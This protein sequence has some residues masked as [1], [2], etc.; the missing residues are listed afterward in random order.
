MISSPTIPGEPRTVDLA[1]LYPPR[2]HWRHHIQHLL[3][4]NIEAVLQEN[5]PEGDNLTAVDFGCGKMPYR[6]IIERFVTRYIGADLSGDPEPEIPI[7]PEGRV[8]LPNGAANLVLS[9][10]V[11]EH[12]EDP[13]AYLREA[14][15]LLKTD[16]RLV[17]S[18]HGVWWYHPH[19]LDLWRWTGEGLRRTVEQAGFEIVD[20]RG[21]MGL[22]ATGM[23]L[24]QDGAYRR[25]PRW[26][27]PAFFFGMQQLV[28]LFDGLSNDEQ[29]QLNASVFL[30]AA[31]RTG[32]A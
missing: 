6:T 19:P 1:T 15:R 8:E 11:L 29:R 13:R 5:R 14:W 17:L 18:T 21:L 20:F 28:R 24:V 25:V 16:G 9:F 31:R 2:S 10:Q 12:V 7:T 22:A 23:H 27:R 30:L 3:S 4:R 26:L 32:T